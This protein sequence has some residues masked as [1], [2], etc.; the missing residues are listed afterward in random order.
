MRIQARGGPRSLTRWRL[1]L[2]ITK[3]HSI[4]EGHLLLANAASNANPSQEVSEG[5]RLTTGVPSEILYCL[6]LALAGSDFGA[7]YHLKASANAVTVYFFDT[8]D[9]FEDPSGEPDGGERDAA[10]DEGDQC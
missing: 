7:V 9:I 3:G 10:A 5:A 8:C 2:W 6:G 1:G 4:R